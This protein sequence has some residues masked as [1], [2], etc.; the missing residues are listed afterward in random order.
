MHVNCGIF[1]Y[2]AALL[3]II[4]IVGCGNSDLGSVD[5]TVRLGGQ[6]LENAIV[7]FTPVTGGRPA[8]G[9][10]DSQGHYQLIFSRDDEG[11][12]IGEHTVSISTY[13]EHLADD[14]ESSVVIPEKVPTRY[15][16]NTE[17]KAK[18]EGGSNT[19][20]FDLEPEG[21]IIQPVE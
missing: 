8:A 2:A 11:A 1:T 6:P 15:N 17:L 16:T 12:L 9:K 14:G 18:V 20:D 7:T 5:G 4:A 13:G 10:T 3:L 21:E 19:L